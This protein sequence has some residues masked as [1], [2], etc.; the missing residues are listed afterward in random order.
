MY[1]IKIWMI[2]HHDRITSTGNS[3]SSI[4]PS[5][6]TTLFQQIEYSLPC[7]AQ[8]TLL[9]T[10]L[11]GHL[12]GLCCPPPC[13]CS[14]IDGA[15]FPTNRETAPMLYQHTALLL[16]L[17][18]HRSIQ[19]LSIFPN[20]SYTNFLLFLTYYTILIHNSKVSLNIFISDA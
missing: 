5:E 10:F 11:K 3:K 4:I 9:A 13:A 16:Y 19:N 2:P 17:T 14:R 1:S 7:V 12:H 18:Y 8:S 15:A 20:T 6:R